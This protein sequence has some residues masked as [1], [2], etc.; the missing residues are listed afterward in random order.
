MVRLLLLSNILLCLNLIPFPF[1]CKKMFEVRE[2][3]V[4]SFSPES[5][6]RLA[7]PRIRSSRARCL[8]LLSRLIA[9]ISKFNNCLG[10]FSAFGIVA[11]LFVLEPRSICILL[12]KL[13]LVKHISP[14]TSFNQNYLIMR[15]G[16]G[17]CMQFSYCSFHAGATR[18]IFCM[19]CCILKL[20]CFKN[21]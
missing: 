12:K 1:N 20:M 17:R 11:N 3:C 8:A 2:E 9:K 10:L 4:N 6:Y 7:T 18:D 16:Y 5:N 14:S 13:T 15:T 19:L 21:P